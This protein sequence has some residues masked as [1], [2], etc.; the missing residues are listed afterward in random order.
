MS[1]NLTYLNNAFFN[2]SLNVCTIV[3]HPTPPGLSFFERSDMSGQT[4]SL[5]TGIFD[6]IRDT[7]TTHQGLEEVYNFKRSHLEICIAATMRTEPG[8]FRRTYREG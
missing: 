1:V 4:S 8:S 2:V 3:E 5:L 6:R 7:Q